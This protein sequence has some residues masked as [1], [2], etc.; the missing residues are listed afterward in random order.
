MILSA[1]KEEMQTKKERV[2]KLR[3][4]QQLK[5]LEEQRNNFA[6]LLKKEKELSASLQKESIH[7]SA[8]YRESETAFYG[9]RTNMKI[10]PS[11]KKGRKLS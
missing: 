10:T 8:A 11:N 5:S 3:R 1:Q 7:E 4:V 2:L 9:R 6:V